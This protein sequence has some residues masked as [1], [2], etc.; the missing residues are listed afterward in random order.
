MKRRGSARWTGHADRGAHLTVTRA[1]EHVHLVHAGTRPPARLSELA[2]WLG[3][4]RDNEAAVLVGA[5]LGDEG[6][7]GLCELLTPVLQQYKDEDVGLLRLVMSAGADEPEGR[8]SA[9]RLLCER[10]ELDIL[11]TAGPAVVVPDGSLFSPDLPDAPGGWWH[12][13]VGEVPRFLGSRLPIPDWESALRRVDDTAPVPDHVIEPVPAGL[14]IRPTGATSAAVHTLPY[15]VPP[16]PDRPHLLVDAPGVPAAGLATMIAALP[17]RVRRDIRLVSLDGHSLLETGQAVADLL[18]TEVHVGNGVPVVV[19]GGDQDGDSDDASGEISTELYAVDAD[20]TPLWRPFA[21]TLTCVPATAER[22]EPARVTSWRAPLPVLQGTDPGALPFE[23]FWK[24]AVTPAGLWVG[25][26][27][28]EPPPAAATRAAGPDVVAIE[29]GAPRRALDDSLWPSLDRLFAQLEPEVRE[30]AVV[31]V[32]GVLGSKGLDHLRRLTIRHSFSLMPQEQA[33]AQDTAEAGAAEFPSLGRT[34]AHTAGESEESAGIDRTAEEGAQGGT[35]TPEPSAVAPPSAPTGEEASGSPVLESAGPRSPELRPG[36]SESSQPSPSRSRTAEPASP[37]AWV[38]ASVSAPTGA[39]R[40]GA[41]EV[42]SSGAVPSGLAFSEVAPS[43]TSS[44]GTSP[45]Q[46]AA[47]QRAGERRVSDP[48]SEGNGAPH[49]AGP[50]IPERVPFEGR[51]AGQTQPDGLLT[52][53]TRPNGPPSP[54]RSGPDGSTRPPARSG[55]EGPTPPP[56]RVPTEPRTPARTP[57]D[58]QEPAAVRA[59]TSPGAESPD[60]TGTGTDPVAG[61]AASPVWEPRS[62]GSPSE[63]AAPAAARVAEPARGGAEKPPAV[64]PSDSDHVKLRAY[65][66]P[67][68]QRHREAAARAMQRLLK[69]QTKEGGSDAAVVELIAVHVYM[70]AVDDTKLRAALAEEDDQSRTLL[71]CLRPGMRRLPSYRGVALSTAEELVSRLG[72][73]AVGGEWTASLPVRATSVSAVHPGTPVD[74]VLIWSV[75]GRRTGDLVGDP[76]GD[77]TQDVLF[78]QESRFRVLGLARR[79]DATVGLLQEVPRQAHAST[80]ALDAALLKRLRAVLDPP[81][82]GPEGDVG[83]PAPPAGNGA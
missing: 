66:A 11:A 31:H 64:N 8:P 57:V 34:Y 77:R 15:A 37:G 56:A 70:T 33:Q 76:A 12:F 52:A 25:P 32:H 51:T 30:R 72:P 4:A 21:E 18:G 63:P 40:A 19:D 67:V 78:A 35:R 69:E 7:A 81:P 2:D 83:L 5:F 1:R 73:D 27:S 60:G 17:G 61:A 36:E 38:S 16:D 74:H 39:S 58:P 44:P 23:Q 6:V 55:S 14:M 45:P 26:R 3:P 59:R 22:A 62:P 28:S 42:A 24:L 80:A 53:R 71:R 54:A 79:D 75:T 82:A 68:W 41:A 20:G 47:E 13:T 10:W 29:L 43:E 46:R 50:R 65:L 48:L 49:Q 9:A